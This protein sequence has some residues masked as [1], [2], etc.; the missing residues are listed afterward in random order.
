[1]PACPVVLVHGVGS[2]F[3]H[4]W[5]N[6]GWVDLLTG[7]GRSVVGVELPGHGREPGR[8]SDDPANR[9]LAQCPAGEPVDAVGFSAG[10]HA[11]LAA[12]ARAPGAF[13]RLA[14]LGVAIPNAGRGPTSAD[15]IADDLDSEAEPPEGPTRVIRRLVATAGNDPHAVAQFIRARRPALSLED[16]AHISL[17]TLVVIG[18]HD[19]VGPADDMV[20]ALPSATLVTLP[21]VDHFATPTDFRCIDAVLRFLAD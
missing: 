18:E 17:P 16:L 5:R 12:A 3:E 14:V 10:G 11:V 2:S 15:A 19:F 21:G 7:E 13:R 8:P 6:T 9:V 1:M 20:A 4:N